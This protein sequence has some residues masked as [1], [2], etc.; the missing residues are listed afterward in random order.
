MTA[1]RQLLRLA[2]L[3]LFLAVW[4]ATFRLG[5]L[6]PIVFGSPSLIA[7]AA[8]KDGWDFLLAFRVTVFEIAMAILIA[9][10]LGIAFGVV[11]GSRVKRSSSPSERPIQFFCISRTLSG[12][13]SSVSSAFNRSSA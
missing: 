12:Q 7:N 4:E 9:W 2:A 10:S 5:L 8:A 1:R 3:V 11:A 13:R 6:S